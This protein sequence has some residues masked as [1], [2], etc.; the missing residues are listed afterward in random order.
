M[1]LGHFRGIIPLFPGPLA[2]PF[3]LPRKISLDNCHS[4]IANYNTI[5]SKGCDAELRPGRNPAD[6]PEPAKH[7]EERN[8]EIPTVCV[9]VG[10]DVVLRYGFRAVR[11]PEALRDLEIAG[12]FVGG[13]CHYR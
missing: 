11:F 1:A 8:D 6:G 13:L 10:F 7:F 4:V 12:G 5:A 9:V 3:R 2:R